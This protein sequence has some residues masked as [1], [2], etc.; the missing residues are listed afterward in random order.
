MSRDICALVI[1][2]NPKIEYV[3][4]ISSYLPH[5]S[6]VM[7]IDNSECSNKELL[8][9][10]PNIDYHWLGENIGIAAALNFGMRIAATEE[11]TTAVT[12]DQDSRF[13]GGQA[14][15]FFGHELKHLFALPVVILAPKLELENISS[16]TLR[17]T[18][19]TSGSIILV[20]A[21]KQ[22]GGFNELLFIDQVDHEFCYKIRRC[23]YRIIQSGATHMEH[24]IGDP[25]D[26]KFFGKRL[27][28]SN[29]NPQRRYYMTR[30]RL[31]LRKM[32]PDFNRQYARMFA[33]DILGILMVEQQKLKKLAAMLLG[34]IDFMRHR[35][36][37]VDLK[38]NFHRSG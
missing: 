24:L 30:N 7:V 32:F 6:K 18:V 15:Y 1:W 10:F 28:S 37:R 29:H 4:N 38:K 22:V 8:K 36:G 23:G 9:D 31:Y 12:F 25:L 27:A 20:D 19:I 21:W 14:E 33:M 2:F 34:A 3:D 26:Y 5:V 35:Y 11:F 13:E 17:D 16:P